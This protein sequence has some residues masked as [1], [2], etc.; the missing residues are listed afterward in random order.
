MDSIFCGGC[1]RAVLLYTQRAY[2]VRSEFL[3]AKFPANAALR[4]ADT[5]KWFGVI[6][7]LP[8]SK[9]GLPGGG[10]VDILDLKGDPRLIGSLIDGR[11]YLS[12]YHMNKEHWF[13]VLLDGSVPPEEIFGLLDLS[14]AITACK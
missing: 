14:F 12:A 13:T 10:D 3:W 5:K 11:R 1:A 4:H 6:I 8:R 2:G 7:R 9:L